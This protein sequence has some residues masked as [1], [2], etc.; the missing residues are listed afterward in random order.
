MKASRRTQEERTAATR[1]ALIEAGRR[2]FA[3]HGFAGVGTETLVREA[4]VSR[5]ALYHQFGDKTELFAEVLAAV[6]ADVTRRLA[7]TVPSGDDGLV[8][9]LTRAVEAWLDACESPE[10]QRI[11]LID[12][13]SV[14]GWVR[15]RAI[16][17][18]HVLGLI[19]AV[20][21]QAAAEG[22]LLP[23]P[24]KPLAHL[25]LAVADE[26]ALYLN[27]ATD[28]AAAR[29]EIV[30]IVDTLVRGLTERPAST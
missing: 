17:Q 8:A 10:V 19:G 13:P 21:A 9:V 7:A 30:Q 26:A 12:G 3:E 15:W 28:R 5:G 24:V 6:E 29:A 20:L 23:L 25:L 16:C 22:E 11:V 1:A 18:P 14:L 27:A 2:L 4:G